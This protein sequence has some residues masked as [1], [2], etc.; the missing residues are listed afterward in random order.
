MKYEPYK[1]IG[2]GIE[3]TKYP[4]DRE[5]S[6]TMAF[7]THPM[8]RDEFKRR[9]ELQRISMTELME[10]IIVDYLNTKPVNP[11][12]KRMQLRADI[13]ETASASR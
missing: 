10:Q 3:Y 9:A 5:K 4:D 11:L 2:R 8:N 1:K 13:A 6:V 12:K 7:R